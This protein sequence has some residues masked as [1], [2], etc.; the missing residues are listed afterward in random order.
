MGYFVQMPKTQAY[1]AV[2]EL[3]L[4]QHG[5]LTAAQARELGVAHKALGSMVDRG[6]L[7]RLA[8]GLFRDLG[9][10][11]TPWTQYAAAVMWPQGVNGVLSHETALALLD[12]S[13]ANPPKIHVTVPKGHRPRRRSPLP[14]MVL[15]HADVSQ[16]ETMSVE[17]LPVTRLWRTIRDCAAT[18]LGPALLR[19]AIEDGL[20]KGYLTE[21]EAAKLRTDVLGEGTTRHG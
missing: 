19:Q 17:G 1:D 9:A 2:H 11:I 12:L 21:L 16:D 20:A 8:Y 10:P 14:G 4:E 15:H 3:A 13:D 18:N 7:D 6:R 5:V